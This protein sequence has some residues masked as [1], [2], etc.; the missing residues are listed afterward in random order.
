MR[1]V[2]IFHPILFAVWPVLLL[3]SEN[4]GMLSVGSAVTPTLIVVS[5]AAVAWCLL[6][7]LLRSKAKAALIV[8][9][10]YFLFFSYGRFVNP[11]SGETIGGFIIEKQRYSLLV[12]LLILGVSSFLIIRARGGLERL[13]NLFNLMAIAIVVF[14]T[15]VVIYEIAQ[16]PLGEHRISSPEHEEFIL[17]ANRAKNAQDRPNIFHIVFDAYTRADCIKRFFG[18]DNSKF[19]EQLSDR[20]FYVAD[21]AVTNY[22]QTSL[23]LASVLNVKY[24][25]DL[26]RQM[27]P[28]ST[29]KKPVISMIQ[30]SRVV[31]F[32][33]K[34]GYTYVFFDSASGWTN[35]PNA[36]IYMSPQMAL[37]ELSG[38]LLG[39]TPIPVILAKAAQVGVWG[40][41]RIQYE[42][43]RRHILY[44][45]DNI[46][47]MAEKPFPVFVFAHILVPHVPFIFGENGQRINLDRDP[48]Q[49]EPTWL[50]DIAVYTEG[51]RRQLRFVNK[52]AIELVDRILAKSRQPPIII[53]QGDHGP[54]NSSTVD[55]KL[56]MKEKFGILYACFLPGGRNN[57]LYPTMS[58]VNT[59]RVILS[60]YFGADLQLLPDRCIYSAFT[61]PYD[62]KDVTDIVRLDW[63]KLPRVPPVPGANSHHNGRK[64]EDVRYSDSV[65]PS[66]ERQKND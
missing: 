46:P 7:L 51:Y 32:L 17:R 37:S 56:R 62:M 55:V 26:T 63:S 8:S 25:N 60:E 58:G 30:Q 1:K 47:R 4:V 3:Y 28:E 29:N 14:P 65:R 13:T 49:D 5:V 64:M 11:Y 23:A 12:L 36:D 61:K 24:L 57:Q 41:L 50:K 45:F 21:Q 43:H 34:K 59:Y 6:S 33:H 53:L 22:A 48:T 38:A 40:A 54:S 15:A 35:T 27:G 42:K 2:L 18:H 31:D 10:S 44:T 19:L 16:S 66:S 39:L 20:G 9:I 52:K